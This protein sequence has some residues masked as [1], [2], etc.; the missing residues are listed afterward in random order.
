M[1]A[2]GSR[3]LSFPKAKHILVEIPGFQIE[4]NLMEVIQVIYRGR[5]ND[6]IDNQDK[7]LIFYLSERSVYYRDNEQNKELSLQESVLNLLNILLILKASIMT[8]IFGSGRVGRENF[9]II[10]IGGKS[11]FAAGDTF[12]AQMVNLIS[13]LKQEYHRNK[14]DALVKNVYTS[15]EQLLGKAEFFVRDATNSNYL[16]LR[17]TFN[18]QFS[19]LCNSLDKLLDFG[20]IERGY[21]SGSLLVV[22]IGN[23]TLEETYQMLLLDIETYANE[24]LWQNMQIIS[25]SKS[26]PESL[27]SA[28]KDA[29][30]LVKKTQRRG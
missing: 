20:K 28:I 15:L 19:Q 16:A 29:I 30:E 10:P 13:Q 5:G 12:S 9:I 17:E 1:T 11:V 26:Y 4:K 7:E 6:K 2:S 21:I 25:H 3:G 14:S 24:K 8:R 23:N 18:S 27:R 22:P